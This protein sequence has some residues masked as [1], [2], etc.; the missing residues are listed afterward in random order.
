MKSKHYQKKANLLK[1]NTKFQEKKTEQKNERP[2]D[3]EEASAGVEQRSELS[4]SF[5]KLDFKISMLNESDMLLI[6][7]IICSVSDPQRLRK[8]LK[9]KK[10]LEGDYRCV[11]EGRYVT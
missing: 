5:K 1:T 10:Q 6:A 2:H 4:I 9:Q 8:R 11:R 3:K 7:F